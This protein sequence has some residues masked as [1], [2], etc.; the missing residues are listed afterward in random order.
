M[1]LRFFDFEVFPHWWCCVF[2][3][4]PDDWEHTPITEELKNSFK[5]VSSDNEFARDVL[6]HY[7]KEE[8]YVQ[9]GYNIKRYDLIIANAIYQGYT[10]EEI[11]IVNDLIINPGCAWDSKQHI[12]LQSVAKKKLYN[13]VYQDLLDDGEGSLKEK[14][15]V[16]GLNILESAVDFNKENLT[17]E[18]K[19]D[20]IYY[21]KQDVY[22]AMQFY[23]QIVSPYTK[24]K[25]AMSKTF[26]IPE[27]VCRA[28][29]N[30]KLVSLVLKAKRH[31][32]ADA[33]KIEIEMPEKIKNYCTENV[34]AD[35]LH[36]L[37]T[38]NE[39]LHAKV[40]DNEVDYGNG[41]IH[42]VYRTN[43]YVES[44]D[45]YCLINVDATSYY[46]SMLIQ[47]DCLSR[48]VEDLSIFP[49][50][51]NERITIKH[52]PIKTEED[53]EKQ[54]ALKLVLNTTFGASGNKYLDLYDPH[55]CTR[56]CRLGQIF[57]TA[58]ANKMH[59]TINSA[60]VI[61][62]NTDGI[63]L[64]V[65]RKDLP[66]VDKLMQEWTDV[67]GINM[68]R[69]DIQKIWQRD[70]NNYLLVMTNGK[71]KRKGAWLNDTYLKPG[72][73]MVGA[74]TAFV[75]AK[76]AKEYLLTGKPIV[77]SIMSDTDVG[78]FVMTCKKGPSYSKVV[79]KLADGTE[80]EL[81][82]CNRVIASKDK[83]LGKIYKLKKYKD[84]V[85]YTQMASIP[86][87]CRLMNYDLSTYDFNEVKKDLDYAYYLVRTMDL[88]NIQWV[89]LS[90]GELFNTHRFDIDI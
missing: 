38:S 58:L 17:E 6:M 9:I 75:C 44:D 14:E 86:D 40:F 7:L 25:L 45:E 66:L 76:A 42:S 10:P 70:V 80:I 18:D 37:L 46:P 47:F 33:D 52:K 19:E 43:L 82:K 48:C 87:N 26:N 84:R 61:Q 74:R 34:P 31:S 81:F 24:T 27:T 73:V 30:A 21:C 22:A 72:Y 13:V 54:L 50:I 53:N 41:G 15:A 71:V 4:M 60:K 88:L 5:V 64:Y 1:K 83:S 12:L 85:S 3:D 63:L 35:I 49:G 39:P 69:D 62:T 32:F 89:E 59:M 68:E 28:S 23:I 65:R 20:V 2:G 8:G 36:H 56:T 55:M 57:L 16:L 11:K 90:K 51:F 29:T 67:S 77:E 79:Q 78:D